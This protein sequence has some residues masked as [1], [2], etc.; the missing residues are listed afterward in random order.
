MSILVDIL[1]SPGSLHH[2]LKYFRDYE[3]DLTSIESRPSSSDFS[4]NVYI[5]FAG[6]LN[7]TASAQ[8]NIFENRFFRLIFELLK[9]CTSMIS[10]VA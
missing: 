2:I 3:I 8:S 5:D 7:A 4:F 1:N 6:K 10:K 9:K